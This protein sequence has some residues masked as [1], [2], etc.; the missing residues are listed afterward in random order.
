MGNPKAKYAASDFE[1]QQ[2]ELPQYEPIANAKAKDADSESE[3][4]QYEPSSSRREEDETPLVKYNFKSSTLFTGSDPLCD[5]LSDPCGSPPQKYCGMSKRTAWTTG[6]M[7]VI[8]ILALVI[9][10]TVGLRL[11]VSSWCIPYPYKTLL[12]LIIEKYTRAMH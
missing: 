6:V 3:P 8:A 5:P 9:G 2:Y 10:L 4:P 12:N 7:V 11:S 1:L